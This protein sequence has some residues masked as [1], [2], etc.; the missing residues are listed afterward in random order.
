MLTHD[1]CFD[2]TLEAF[3]ESS[4]GHGSPLAIVQESLAVNRHPTLIGTAV[5][6]GLMAMRASIWAAW[7]VDG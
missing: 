5:N 1:E 4:F 7:Q 3:R 6:F 2:P